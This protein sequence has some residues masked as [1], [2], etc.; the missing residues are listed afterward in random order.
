MLLIELNLE[1]VRRLMI[2]LQV[3]RNDLIQ[4]D[5]YIGYC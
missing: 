2:V 4:I 3:F 5:F 1:E